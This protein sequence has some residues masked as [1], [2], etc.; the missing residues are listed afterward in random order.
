MTEILDDR[1][2]GLWLG[3]ASGGLRR[4]HSDG[5]GHGARFTIELPRAPNGPR[6]ER[7][8]SRSAAVPRILSTSVA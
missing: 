5:A 1:L 2:G 7:P 3:T 6:D 8:H 4:V